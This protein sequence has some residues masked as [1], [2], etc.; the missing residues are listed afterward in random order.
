MFDFRKFPNQQYYADVRAK[1]INVKGTFIAT[2]AFLKYTGD[3]PSVPTTIINV[4]S[5]ST[6]GVAPGFN[7]YSPAK[8]AVCKFTQ[9]LA[10]EH[11]TITSINIDPGIVATDMAHSV[12]YLAPFIGDTPELVGGTAVWLSSG[13]KSFLSGK[14]VLVCWDVE[15]LER[16]KAEIKESKLLTFKLDGEF[17]RPDVTVEKA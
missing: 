9:F 1:E 10:V 12:P 6:Q 5:M 13:D 7:S 4:I 8:L 15:E 14:Y 11:P 17:G 3:A 16:R 2:K